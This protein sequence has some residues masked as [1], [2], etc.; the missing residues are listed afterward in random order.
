MLVHMLY[1]LNPSTLELNAWYDVQQME[2]K[3]VQ[4]NRGH[5]RLLVIPVT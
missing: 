2:F 3:W 1:E 4:H 5:E